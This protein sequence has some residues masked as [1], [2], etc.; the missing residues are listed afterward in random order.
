M[1]IQREEQIKVKRCVVMAVCILACLS[2]ILSGCNKSNKLT[3]TWELD[4]AYDFK[5]SK[6]T[7]LDELR[8]KGDDTTATLIFKSDNTYKLTYDPGD[9]NEEVYT[10]TYEFSEYG[11]NA[12]GISI[13]GNEDMSIEMLYENNV[14]TFNNK[15]DSFMIVSK[16]KSSKLDLDERDFYLFRKK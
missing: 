6:I 3:G 16:E 14:P 12:Y 8:D 2:F 7:T 15:H 11:N 10:G 9:K 1:V 4:G 5:S 13:R